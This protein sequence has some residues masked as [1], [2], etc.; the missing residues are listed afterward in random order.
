MDRITG[1]I[2]AVLAGLVAALG[3]SSAIAAPA[4]AD[5]AATA[6]AAE[7]TTVCALKGKKAKAAEPR[8]VSITAFLVFNADY[9][10]L[11]QEPSWP[12]CEDKIDGTG[13]LRIEL[14]DGK[15]LKNF[16]VLKKA[17]SQDYVRANAGKRIYCTCVGQVSNPGSGPTFTLSRV[18]K[19]WTDQAKK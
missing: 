4:Q 6:N 13:L 15:T 14:P 2:A 5:A 3:T 11:L 9:G 10:Y 7:R 19:L 8:T 1:T 17:S 12:S 18:E 16:P